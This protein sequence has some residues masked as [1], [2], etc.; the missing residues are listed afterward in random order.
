MEL[1]W[2]R[3]GRPSH[4]AAVAGAFL[5][6]ALGADCFLAVGQL[7]GL[8]AF[9]CGAVLA[10][11]A[12][13]GGELLAGRR[14]RAGA[15]LSLPFIL[16][17]SL[18]S[19][20][21]GFALVA[22]PGDPRTV[23]AAFASLEAAHELQYWL[24][25]SGLLGVALIVW[26]MLFLRARGEELLADR[27]AQP[28]RSIP[29]PTPTDMEFFLPSQQWIRPIR[30]WM[31]T[32]QCI[33][34]ALVLLCG[35]I[36]ALV[37]HGEFWIPVFWG[38]MVGFLFLQVGQGRGRSGRIC[39]AGSVLYARTGDELWRV[40]MN[41]IRDPELNAPL[42]RL[43]RIWD[44]LPVSRQ[45][46]FRAAVA[47]AVKERVGVSRAKS[48]DLEHESRWEWRIADLHGCRWVIPKVY[49]NFAPVSSVERAKEPLPLAWNEVICIP[50]VMLVCAAAGCFL[51]VEAEQRAVDVPTPP[52]QVETVLPD[53][54]PFSLG[55]PAPMTT[56]RIPQEIG[57][58][59][60]NGL[61]LQTDDSFSSTANDLLDQ[62]TN[63]G[64]RLSLRYGV[65]EEAVRA[66]L[67]E[68]GQCRYLRPDSSE[69]LWRMGEN[70][71][72][73]QYNL[74]TVSQ[75]DGQTRHTGAA[76][77]ERG[78]LLVIEA[79]HGGDVD[80]ETVRGDLLYMLENLQFTGPA[81]NNGNYQEQLR[82][83]VNMGFNYCGQAFLKAPPGLFGYDAF[84]DTFLP[85]GGALNYYDDGLSVMT[86]VHGLRVSAAIVPCDGTA[87]DALDGIY[88]DLKAAG[89]QYDE[90]NL[91]EDAYSE[92]DNTAC[93]A[94]VYYDGGRTRATVMYAIGKW[95]GYYLF[96][97]MT[98]LPEEIDSEYPAVFKEMEASS[99]I[100]VPHMETMGQFGQ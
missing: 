75:P 70:S 57:Y 59:Y 38:V 19:N 77:S 84:I 52:P 96:K 83:A 7:T 34:L 88:Q 18:L 25:L 35:W 43:A 86:S 24:Q 2:E 40:D 42:A 47:K 81:I 27:A 20:H 9:L 48:P 16:L 12:V 10:F 50:A 94:T 36:S 4:A 68:E 46:L 60:L 21:L 22:A 91:Y 54:A 80:E 76:L 95:E 14:S 37:G 33:C 29:E 85:C 62:K 55:D 72:V 87:K 5:G 73:Y 97:E 39:E 99:G 23:W 66:V 51:G 44:Q 65:G 30:I 17:W 92:E 71:V 100:S 6:G 53:P 74:R 90:Q 79:G 78:T 67:K 45:K 69:L 56:A 1:D 28:C 89:R 11:W 15:L 41:S 93:I 3:E 82:P 13:T 61:T 58:Y 63:V 26:I 98:C 8:P 32:V 49:P 64:Y 31:R